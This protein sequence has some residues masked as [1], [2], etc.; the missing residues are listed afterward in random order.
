MPPVPRRGVVPGRGTCGAKMPCASSLP[1]RGHGCEGGLLSG[2]RRWGRRAPTRRTGPAGG[3]RD[4]GGR[5]G[6][7]PG[8]RL[9]PRPGRMRGTGR[10]PVWLKVRRCAG[11][12]RARRMRG[13]RTC[14][15]CLTLFGGAQRSGTQSGGRRLGLRLRHGK[16]G[17][18]GPF[19]W[20][21]D[22]G[23][24]WGGVRKASGGCTEHQFAAIAWRRG[25]GLASDRVGVASVF[26]RGSGGPR[27]LQAYSAGGVTWASDGMGQ[28]MHPG[29][30]DWPHCPTCPSRPAAA[31]PVFS[32]SIRQS[33]HGQAAAGRRA[34]PRRRKARRIGAASTA[35]PMRVRPAARRSLRPRRPAT[36]SAAVRIRAW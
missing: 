20:W 15:E 4:M 30:A 22:L 31:Q 26:G 18:V 28:G 8:R 34:A 35:G 12:R 9:Y 6:C 10:K 27:G 29:D 5:A 36:P 2:R 1:G 3:M 32:A 14:R 17:T 16:R 23:Q 7:G 11:G 21:R 19:G 25:R 13:A 24:R 33:A